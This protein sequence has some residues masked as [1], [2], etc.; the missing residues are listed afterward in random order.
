M[1]SQI[2]AWCYRFGKV[3]RASLDKV[4]GSAPCRVEVPDG[5]SVREVMT[6]VLVD[7]AGDRVSVNAL[8]KDGKA[9]VVPGSVGKPERAPRKASARAQELAGLKA[10]LEAA[11]SALRERGVA[12]P[13]SGEWRAAT[14]S[15][16]VEAATKTSPS[17]EPSA[18]IEVQP[19]S[20]RKSKKHQREHQ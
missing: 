1:S 17:P 4:I 12:A 5:Y 2:D 20:S 19:E 9:R 3:E 16:L 6:H 14:P 13:P 15:D 7:E 11:E 10:R 8:M 18:P